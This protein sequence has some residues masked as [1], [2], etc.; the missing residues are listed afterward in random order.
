MVR[1]Q[2][3]DSY[4]DKYSSSLG[5]YYYNNSSYKQA[6]RT[7]TI[8]AE[9]NSRLGNQLQNM[10]R[11]SAV[12]VRDHRETKYAAPTMYIQDKVY[13]DLG[14]EYSSG[15]NSMDSNTFT[16][17]DNLSWYLGDH[18]LVFGTHNEVYTFNNL[19]LQYAYGQYNF[20][21]IKDF[22]E[23]NPNQFQY[24]YADPEVTGSDDPHW[25]A[26]TYAAQFG[27]YV[28]DEWKP[29]RNLTVTYGIRADLPV[30]LNKPTANEEYNATD[31]AKNNNEY[32]GVVPK[33]Q[34]LWSPRVG[35]RWFLNDDHTTLLRGGA[36]LFTGRV[37]FVWISNAYNNTGMEAKGLTVK[38]PDWMD[39]ADVLK[40][41]NPYESI[42]RSGLAAASGK[43]TINT[44][45]ENFKYPQV[46]RV[47]LG[48]EQSFLD[49]WKFTFDGMYSKTLNNVYFRNL[50][51]KDHGVVYA[52]SADA[53]NANNT[54]PNFTLD[55]AYQAIVALQNTNKGYTY[56]FTGKLE[57]SFNFGLDAMVAYT[58]TVSRSVNDG[59]SSVAL[60]NWNNFL[61]VDPNSDELSYSLFDK[62]HKVTALLSYTTPTYARILS[63]NVT[64]S[65]V[66]GSGSR[67]SYNMNEG[68]D[69]NGDGR[70]N[71]SLL[72]VPT[73]DEV[74]QMSWSNPS[75]AAAFENFIRNDAYLSSR[76]GQFT[77][78]N[79]GITPFEHHFDL[80]VSQ[81]IFYDK[82]NNRKVEIMLDMINFS[83]LLNRGWGL[84][85]NNPWSRN[86]LKVES[87]AEDAQGNVTPTY[88]FSP[89][90]IYTS[91]FNS[92][93]RCQL[94]VRV[95]F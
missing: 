85:Y 1:Y 73:Q 54:A 84:Y 13:I 16:L 33:P 79:G 29:N 8:V 31:I 95:T 55:N 93:W 74:G 81:N 92:R 43:A 89:A 10:L 44:I 76:R 36:G 82:K 72:Y 26:T 21:T 3:S 11:A 40:N 90:T 20:S 67:Y 22:F 39:Q 75:D 78:R 58:Y 45:N 80:H 30:F 65:Y 9:L 50:A 41:N 62:P 35:F 69:L 24:R 12:M 7:N 68:V 91:D 32:V 63:T 57:K 15:A 94:G 18:H 86:I 23:D 66:G 28:Q 19:F 6:D 5:T 61:A 77:E 83:N 47:N 52:V 64:I 87:I 53:A 34:V 17:T 25:K 37:P 59:G 46:F 27:L 42:V 14:T 2:F 48:F 60:S 49:G 88:S 4:A 51:L 70:K 38:N 56:S 71:N